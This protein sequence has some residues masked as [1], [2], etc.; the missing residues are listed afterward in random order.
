[1]WSSQYLHEKVGDKILIY[2]VILTTWYCNGSSFILLDILLSQYHL[3]KRLFFLCW[4]P[5]WKSAATITI[6]SSKNDII[7]KNFITYFFMQVLRWSHF[8][9]LTIPCSILHKQ[10]TFFGGGVLLKCP[11]IPGITICDYFLPWIPF[12]VPCLRLCFGGAMA[13]PVWVL[14]K[15]SSFLVECSPRSF[16]KLGFAH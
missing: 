4:D 15:N 3:W 9:P 16:W 8:S 6:S 14:I 7:N 5:C 10:F 11:C 13:F 2:D 1:M 12:L